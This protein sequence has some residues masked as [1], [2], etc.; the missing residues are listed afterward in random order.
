MLKLM[1]DNVCDYWQDVPDF[2]RPPGESWWCKHCEA[3][4]APMREA[5]PADVAAAFV[6]QAEVSGAG[7]A[8]RSWIA[9]SPLLVAAG[10]KGAA[11]RLGLS[12]LL[13][14]AEVVSEEEKSCER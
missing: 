1:V 10:G 6:A 3:I 7:H 9:A 11:S 13:E 12:A 8:L 4:H 5:T 14:E 2:E